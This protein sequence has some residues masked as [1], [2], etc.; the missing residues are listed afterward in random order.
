MRHSLRDWGAVGKANHRSTSSYFLLGSL[1]SSVYWGRCRVHTSDKKS[2]NNFPMKNQWTVLT[3]P[4]HFSLLGALGGALGGLGWAV[5]MS[6]SSSNSKQYCCDR[7]ISQPGRSAGAAWW[8]R[9]AVQTL[10][11]SRG[12]EQPPHF[13]AAIATA[14]AATGRTPHH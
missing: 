6:R 13:A 14:C 7:T 11:E 4:S 1:V 8:R 2:N 12:D 10:T 5:V 3:A 9:L